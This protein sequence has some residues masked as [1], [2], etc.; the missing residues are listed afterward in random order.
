MDINKVIKLKEYEFLKTNE[1]LGN[2]IMFVTLGGSHAYG[3]NIETSDIDIRGIALNSPDELIGIKEWEQYIDK[4]TDTTIYSFNKIVKLLMNV[5][6]NV[7]EMLGCKPEHYALLSP[8]GKLLLDNKHLFLSQKAIHSFGGYAN[9]QLRRLQNAI[10]RDSAPQSMKEEHI[11]N[12]IEFAMQSF[13][14]K[15]GTFDKN[16]IALS[17]ANSNREGLYKEILVD[18][19]MKGYPLRGFISIINDMNNVIRTYDKLNHRNKKKDEL[20]LNKHAMHLV[21]LYIM[22]LDILKHGEINT[23]REI[24]HDFLM[25]IR[26][27][28]F[29]N[30][31]GT[32][33][34]E[35][36]DIIDDYE[37]KVLE[38][39]KYTKLP[40]VPDYEKIN[41]LVK[42]INRIAIEIS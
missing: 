18:V 42:K 32:Y 23:Y 6:P 20:H 2:R 28:Y 8:A 5:N 13:H 41:E 39:V 11:K 22:C 21:R 26:N 40:E 29:V 1:H 15:Y 19:Q 38:A 31:D 34:Q 4:D 30:S 27:G 10:A 17:I 24:E 37:K 7:I 14:G 33:K 16:S 25:A 9:S 36:F 12:S 35:F 3:T